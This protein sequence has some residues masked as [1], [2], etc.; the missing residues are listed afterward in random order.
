MNVLAFHIDGKLPLL[1]L[2]RAAAHYRANGDYFEL[3]KAGN[4]QAVEPRLGDREW[5]LVIASTIFEWS[6]PVAERVRS[7]Y[8]EAVIGGT[9]W[10]VESSLTELGIQDGP[11]DYSD[12]SHSMRTAY[13]I[14]YLSRGCRLKCGFCVVPRKEGKIR[15]VATVEQLWRGE[16]WPREIVLL[17]N[18]FFGN[19]NWSTL[20]NE[21]IAG[22][23]KVC[24]CQGI[25]ARFL[26]DES[27]AAIASVDYRDERMHERRIYTAWDGKRDEKRLFR[28]LEALVRHGVKPDHIMVY[29][30]IGYDDTHADREYRRAKLREFGARPYP[31]VY[32]RGDAFLNCFK[33]WVIGAYDKI[34]P[35]TGKPFITWERWLAAKGNPRNLGSRR[36]TLPLFD[37]AK[38]SK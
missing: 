16:P 21:M 33:G 10:K 9:G 37:E 32:V 8:P 20:I 15:S 26:D 6:R 14:G 38:G 2:M 12:Y 3:R 13:S 27:A 1:S 23:F 28:G 31:M 34:D 30:L 17:D 24:F 4:V 5:D 22:R 36:V 11:L 7:V 19:P 35:K 29:M 18:D 25:N